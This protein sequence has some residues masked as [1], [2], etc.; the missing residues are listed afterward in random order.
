MTWAWVLMTKEINTQYDQARLV[1]LASYPK[2]GNTWLRSFLSALNVYDP[3]AEQQ[4]TEQAASDPLDDEIDMNKIHLG[5]QLFS[6]EE[7]EVHAGFDTTDLT[8]AQ[9]A[10]LRVVTNRHY[11]Q[12][13]PMG[14]VGYMKVH[15]AYTVFDNGACL[16][17]KQYVKGVVYIVRNPLDVVISYANQSSF[18]IDASIAHFGSDQT[19]GVDEKAYSAESSARRWISS[20]SGHVQ[21]WTSG[22]PLPYLLVRYEDMKKRGIDTFMQVVH[23]LNL[24]ASEEEVAKAL[25]KVAFEKFAKQEK[26]KPFVESESN[27]DGFFRKGIVGDWREVLSSAQISQVISDHGEMMHQLGYVDEYGKPTQLIC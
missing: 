17:D 23:F 4:F 1:L 2:S 22:H 19:L 14:Q 8:E 18:S 10:H 16:F 24:T 6:R 20:W 7:I 3:L 15:D 26:E 25:D 13:I 12:A 5:T 11:A 21:S 27:P 9:L